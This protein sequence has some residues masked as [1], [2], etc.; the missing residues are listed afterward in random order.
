MR[1]KTVLLISSL[2]LLFSCGPEPIFSGKQ[3]I[4]N[5]SWTYGDIKS[6]EVDIVDTLAIYNMELII[7]HSYDYAHENV[8]M[9]IYTDFPTIDQKEER[10]TVDL[11]DSNGFWI[12]NCNG[13]KCKVKV[14]LLENFKFP[15][16]GKYTFSFEQFTRKDTL[17]GINALSLEIYESIQKN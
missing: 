16:L 9:K 1:T 14:Y 17:L 15:E 3:D 6:F 12:G 8:Y 5:Q 11:S 13:N 2:L 7:D 4:E 10:I